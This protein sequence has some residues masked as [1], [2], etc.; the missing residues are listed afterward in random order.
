V[1]NKH[2]SYQDF[3][4]TNSTDTSFIIVDVPVT[5]SL[6]QKILVL[7]KNNVP[8]FTFDEIYD[9]MSILF[10]FK[11]MEGLLAYAVCLYLEENP[12]VLKKLRQCHVAQ[13]KSAF[14]DKIVF[15]STLILDQ[16]GG[17]DSFIEIVCRNI[18][19]GSCHG[20]EFYD[21]SVSNIIPNKIIHH[22]LKL[23]DSSIIFLFKYINMSY[24]F[25]EGNIDLL[26]HKF[27]EDTLHK[28]FTVRVHSISYDDDETNQSALSENDV[29]ERKINL[30]ATC[31]LLKCRGFERVILEFENFSIPIESNTLTFIPALGTISCVNCTRDFIN[32]LPQ[33]V[34]NVEVVF[35]KTHDLNIRYLL[36]NVTYVR[37]LNAEFDGNIAFIHNKAEIVILSSIIKEGA[38][39]TFPS[40]CSKVYIRNT[41]GIFNMSGIAGFK[42]I[43]TGIYNKFESYFY[44]G[45]DSLVI[46]NIMLDISAVYLTSIGTLYL[47]FVIIPKQSFCV[48]PDGIKSLKILRSV[49]LFNLSPYIGTSIRIQSITSIVIEPP[50]DKNSKLSSI[51]LSDITIDREVELADK[52]ETVILTNVSVI[53]QVSLILNDKCRNL[54]CSGYIGNITVG[55]GKQFDVIKINCTGCPPLEIRFSNQISVRHLHLHHLGQDMSAFGALLSNFEKIERFEISDGYI[56]PY[57][58]EFYSF[59]GNVSMFSPHNLSENASKELSPYKDSKSNVG[60]SSH[61]EE[62]TCK[63]TPIAWASANAKISETIL[64]LDFRNTSATKED[65]GL[66]QN[67]SHLKIVRACVD[68]V[69]NESLIQIPS[70]IRLLELIN[71]I[72]RKNVFQVQNQA[73][74]LNPLT[75][76]HSLRILIVEFDIFITVCKHDLLPPRLETIMVYFVSDIAKHSAINQRVRVRELLI[77]SKSN[78]AIPWFMTMNWSETLHFINVLTNYVDFKSLEHLA[79]VSP[80]DLLAL[81][82]ANYLIEK[83]Q[84][85]TTKFLYLEQIM[86]HSQQVN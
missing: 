84:S 71:S 61:P 72:N 68:N 56:S 27:C 36:E 35:S 14:H 13:D 86:R 18:W 33:D 40:E 47:E 20:C 11:D 76:F 67:L 77:G 15:L 48:V 30:L 81:N 59:S 6:F 19:F 52:Y 53:P 10:P 50:S 74:W 38:T 42:M 64:E 5:I 60:D 65:W 75:T 12:N 66:L 3:I 39:I 25:L 70:N 17:Q 58:P 80:G 82:P 57:I 44:K 34:K 32:S 78:G 23:E 62:L 31:E 83:D 4:K 43:T 8:K 69:H 49:G 29:L 7:T 63:V 21:T 37:F 55:K 9:I 51:H 79:V 45:S 54:T 26:N 1:K 24:E 2:E 73:E 22:T 28:A 85:I 46:Q 16:N 41:S